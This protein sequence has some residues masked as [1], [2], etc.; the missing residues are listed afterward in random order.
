MDA[1]VSR[2]ESVLMNVGFHD[3]VS[4]DIHG[5]PTTVGLDA[6]GEVSVGID[7]PEKTAE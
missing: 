7:I 4:L 1:V 2:V 6:E 3:G 5:V